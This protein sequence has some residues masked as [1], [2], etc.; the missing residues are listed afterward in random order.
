MQSCVDSHTN[1]TYFGISLHARC[2]ETVYGVRCSVLDQ[3]A[4]GNRHNVR[5]QRVWNHNAV[6]CRVFHPGK[7]DRKRRAGNVFISADEAWMS[8]LSEKRLIV[9]DSR[10][11]LLGNR[12]VLVAPADSNLKVD[13][14]PSF[15]LA[16]L[17]GRTPRNRR[18]GSCPGG[19][20][21]EDSARQVG[22]LGTNRRQTR[23]SRQCSRSARARGTRGMSA[24][25]RV[26]DGCSDFQE[27]KIVGTFPEGSHPPVT[28]PAALITGKDTPEARGFLAFLKTPD[29]NAVFEST[30]SRC[31]NGISCAITSGKGSAQ[32]EPLG[33]GLGRSGQLA[34]G[35]LLAWLLARKNFPG[36]LL[37]D[38]VV[39]LP[40]VLPP[41][42]MG[43]ILLV[44]H[45]RKGFLGAWFHA[46]FG[47]SFAFNWKG[48]LLPRELWHFH[49]W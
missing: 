27:V 45:G 10:F 2:A 31:G 41:V 17:R 40:L 14:K 38:G 25:H 46:A 7:T 42:V 35:I 11:D 30:G 39:H 26:F 15:P 33:V 3:C 19:Q 32:F 23:E 12:V 9:P 8:Y 20:V 29:A 34:C 47:I 28:Y 1:I 24:W 18:S 48:A 37:L 13:I 21:C 36:K 16:E 44:L 5:G 22:S 49:S 43:Y 6:L 4:D